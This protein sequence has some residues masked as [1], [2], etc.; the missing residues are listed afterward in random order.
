MA[1]VETDQTVATGKRELAAILGWA[2]PRLDRRIDGD[3]DFPIKVRGTRAG[4]WE[5][6]VAAVVAYLDGQTAPPTAQTAPAPRAPERVATATPETDIGAPGAAHR[7]EATASQRLR[8][9]Q[10]ARQEDMLRK[11]RREL[12]EAE[13]MRLVLGTMLARLGKG[14]DGLPDMIVRRLGVPE[15]TADL[16]REMVDDLRRAMVA[17][18]QP[19]LGGQ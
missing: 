10:A 3:L 15:E 13:E 4:G 8:N 1:R 14:L 12:V 9:A 17:E 19:L 6:D 18:L 16:L 11:D 2:R 5:F 7:G